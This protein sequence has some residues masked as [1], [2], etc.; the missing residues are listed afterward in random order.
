M[1]IPGL[2]IKT[3]TVPTKQVSDELELS[4]LAG[5]EFLLELPK[6]TRIDEIALFGDTFG[7]TSDR[8]PAATLDLE[9]TFSRDGFRTDI[10]TRKVSINRESTFHNLYK[11]HVYL[12][13]CYRAT[14]LAERK[15]E[16]ASDR[17]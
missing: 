1:F 7:A 16:V 13:E 11:G 2:A 10:R 14:Q 3:R 5:A 6:P 17:P 15:A 8:P 12:F 9:L 4:P